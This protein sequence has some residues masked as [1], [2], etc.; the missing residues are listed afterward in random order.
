MGGG[1]GEQ[2]DT[3]VLLTNLSLKAAV[4]DAKGLSFKAF[5]LL[6]VV[7]IGGS[8]ANSNSKLGFHNSVCALL[9]KDVIVIVSILKLLATKYLLLFYAILIFSTLSI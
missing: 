7:H 4:A 9:D 2:G 5:R 3:A 6:F 1:G 8:S